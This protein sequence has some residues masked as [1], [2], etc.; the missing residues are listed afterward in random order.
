MG[1]LDEDGYC[2]GCA[3]LSPWVNLCL[4]PECKG[5][6]FWRWLVFKVTR[7]WRS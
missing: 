6:S 3:Y 4:N 5:F 1:E 7:L 2:Q